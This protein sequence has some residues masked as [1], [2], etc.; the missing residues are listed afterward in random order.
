MPLF[1]VS[2][3]ANNLRNEVVTLM[4]TSAFPK[5]VTN[6]SFVTHSL[7]LAVHTPVV[8][9]QLASKRQC[10][11]VY[12]RYYNFTRT[13]LECNA[14]VN[15]TG[16]CTCRHNTSKCVADTMTHQACV[17]VYAV[18]E[19]QVATTLSFNKSRSL[20]TMCSRSQASLCTAPHSCPSRHTITM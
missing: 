11:Y 7:Q 4:C 1:A 2:P 13:F 14:V 5:C 19:E 17:C 18:V 12:D 15:I 20:Q 8:V 6:S 3:V 9:P 10:Q 16:K